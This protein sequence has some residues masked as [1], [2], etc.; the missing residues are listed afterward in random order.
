MERDL[1]RA[2]SHWT[3]WYLAYGQ[4]S[5]A[6]RALPKGLPMTLRAQRKMKKPY[7]GSAQFRQ[8]AAIFREGA[9]LWV[10]T[11]K[12]ILRRGADT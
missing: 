12:A 8:L 5:E 1:R 10:Y 3:N 2:H 9:T 6:R 7:G 11:P 4:Y